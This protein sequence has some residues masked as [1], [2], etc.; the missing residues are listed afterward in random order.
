[1]PGAPSSV[2]VK[3]RSVLSFGRAGRPYVASTLLWFF[4]MA[5]RPRCRTW[6]IGKSQVRRR[7]VSLGAKKLLGAPGR[8]T[9]SKDAKGKKKKRLYSNLIAAFNLIGMASESTSHRSGGLAQALARA[10]AVA[11]NALASPYRSRRHIAAIGALGESPPTHLLLGEES[12][13]KYEAIRFWTSSR[14]VRLFGMSWG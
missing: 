1:M 14:V 8:T 5:M 3:A 12:V 2:L 7:A 9:K 10:K 13:E 6:L 4:T 11:T